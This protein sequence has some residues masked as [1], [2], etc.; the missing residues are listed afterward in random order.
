M[1]NISKGDVVELTSPIRGFEC[2]IPIGSTFKVAD[3]NTV[4]NAVIIQ[5][6][7]NRYGKDY[8]G[9]YFE[10]FGIPQGMFWNVSFDDLKKKR[11]RM[12]V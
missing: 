9:W 11:W 1:R 8:S 3:I 10:R 7:P 12:D 5:L 6:S 2:M 4:C